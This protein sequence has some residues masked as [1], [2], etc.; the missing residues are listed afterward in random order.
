[1]SYS[2][3]V[4]ENQRLLEEHTRRVLNQMPVSHLD[5]EER[6]RHTTSARHSQALAPSALH[7]DTQDSP[8]S[9]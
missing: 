2:P 9:V 6:R 4:S 3:P 8:V 5:H 1:M 7:R